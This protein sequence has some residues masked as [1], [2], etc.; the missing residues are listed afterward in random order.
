MTGAWEPDPWLPPH[1]YISH[2]DPAAGGHEQLRSWL[3]ATG[4]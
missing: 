3:D 4:C 1:S 2:H